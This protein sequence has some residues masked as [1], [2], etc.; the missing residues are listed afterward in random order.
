MGE[1]YCRTRATESLRGGIEESTTARMQTESRTSVDF[2]IDY[3]DYHRLDPASHSLIP[4]SD[5]VLTSDQSII[6]L[7]FYG[8]FVSYSDYIQIGEAFSMLFHE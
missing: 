5:N 6:Y 8:K 1:Y 2:V 4:T 3:T 7:G